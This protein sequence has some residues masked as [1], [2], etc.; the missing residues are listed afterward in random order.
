[1]NTTTGPTYGPLNVASDKLG[2]DI[3]QRMVLLEQQ[4]EFYQI[5]FDALPIP[6]FTIDNE[7]R[8]KHCNQ[9][10]ERVMQQIRE[11]F[12]GSHVDDVVGDS[13]LARVIKC[14]AKRED[15]LSQVDVRNER[16]RFLDGSFHDVEVR[17]VFTFNLN[18][19][20]DGAVGMLIDHTDRLRA[21]KAEI[22]TEKLRT[23]QKL[24]ISVAHE[25]NNPLMIVSGVHQLARAMLSD[26]IDGKLGEQLDRV[27]RSIDRMKELVETLMN[28]TELKESEYIKGTNFF[29]LSGSSKKKDHGKSS[30]K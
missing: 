22:E 17:H 18:G 16:I 3:S 5:L 7:D 29:D 28:L 27:P 8:F 10:F 19:E 13:T 9:A 21:E 12:I 23:A 2:D 24:A 6:V 30:K 15:I 1:M 26:K 4:V 25:F 20:P 14:Q 11:E